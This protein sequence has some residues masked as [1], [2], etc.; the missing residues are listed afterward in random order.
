MWPSVECISS[1]LVRTP[2]LQLGVLQITTRFILNSSH[3]PFS[4]C[5]LTPLVESRA[6]LWQVCQQLKRPKSGIR[7]W[8]PL[9][10]PHQPWCESSWFFPLTDPH[11][12]TVQSPRCSQI[13]A[14]SMWN[15][16]QKV[17]TSLVMASPVPWSRGNEED[18]EPSSPCWLWVQWCVPDTWSR[19]PLE[20][21]QSCCREHALV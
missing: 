11:L 20:T 8:T 17:A 3:L 1:L 15:A 19:G 13:H 18:H 5:W 16:N 12:S 4:P 6:K 2:S 10:R 21:L 14:Q 7:E 9:H